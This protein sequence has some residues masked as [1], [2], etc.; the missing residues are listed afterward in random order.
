MRIY[1]K[2]PTDYTP[3]SEGNG[4]KLVDGLITTKAIAERK[5]LGFRLKVRDRRV[6]LR[7]AIEEL[8]EQLVNSSCNEAEAITI[9]DYCYL[10][11]EDRERGYRARVGFFTD[12]LTGLQGNI[13]RG[14]RVGCST[15]FEIADSSDRFGAG[16]EFKFMELAKKKYY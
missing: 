10:R 2:S 14:Q 3:I 9:L 13:V 6:D 1:C 8:A 12:S 7:I 15:P 4:L 16:F 5:R 11:R